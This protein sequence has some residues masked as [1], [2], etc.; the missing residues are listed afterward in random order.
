M[1]LISDTHFD[2][3]DCK[4]MDP[5]WPS[6]EEHIANI[7]S[8]IGKFDTLI[9]LGDVGDP[10]YM[11]RV[12]CRKVLITGNHDKGTA[13]YEPYFDEIYTGPLFIGEKILLSH[14]PVFG[15]PWCRNIHGH[16]HD[17]VITDGCHINL[18]ANV[19]GYKPLSLGRLIQ[20]GALSGFGGIHRDTVDRINKEKGS[21][22]SC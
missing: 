22:N 13:V 4:Y 8:H 3:F 19:V 7:A 5:N 21:D 17:G 12:R 15:L 11:D 2:D 14:E 16:N 9:H 18:A 6:P 1:W 10:T 20:Y